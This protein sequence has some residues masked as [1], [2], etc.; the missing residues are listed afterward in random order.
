MRIP[1]VSLALVLSVG[2]A[3][4]PS[5]PGV[6]QAAAWRGAS[7]STESARPAAES[8]L[9]SADLPRSLVQSILDGY[10]RRIE[11]ALHNLANQYT[12]GYKRKVP[13]FVA[14]PGDGSRV[15]RVIAVY[16]VGELEMTNRNLDLAIDG[17]G[18]FRVCLPSGFLEYTR[19]GRLGINDEGKLV[20]LAGYVLQPEITIPSDILEINIDREGRVSGRLASCPDTRADFGQLNLFRF[21]NPVGLL[22]TS[23]NLLRETPESGPAF[24]ATSSEFGCGSLHQGFLERSN[25]EAGHELVE[26]QHAREAKE[27][28]LRSVGLF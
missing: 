1:F 2:C 25:V 12:A 22:E 17:D 6:P 7:V 19:D 24:R 5:D 3:S 10:D 13:Q 16:S 4:A 14:E 26:L 15:A 11:L 28:F 18:F 20:T 27:R 21:V 8:R 23:M 9:S